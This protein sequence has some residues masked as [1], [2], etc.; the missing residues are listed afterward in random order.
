MA[1][2]IFGRNKLINICVCGGGNLAHAIA[3][4]LSHNDKNNKVS[5]LT[6]KP[7]RW[8]NVLEVQH[9]H[10][11]AYNS[12]L[13]N[14]TN[15]YTILENM[16][17]II[18]SIP[19][20][21]RFEFLTK[22][23]KHVPTHAILVTAPSL[24]GI[25]FIFDKYFPKNKY[26]CLQRVP[27]ICRTVEYG[28]SVNTDIKKEIK[29]LHS[30]NST[31][32]DKNIIKKL[33]K[34]NVV[35]LKSYRALMLSNS[36]PILHIAGMAQLIKEN[37]P[38]NYIPRL[39]DIWD[40]YASNICIEMDKELESIMN[41]YND[42]EYVSLFEHYCVNSTTELTTKLKSITSFKD[43][44][45]PFSEKNGLYYIDKTSRYI[46]EDIPFGTCFIKYVAN[47]NGIKTPAIDQVLKII[48]KTIGEEYV[49]E[50][51]KINMEHW[52]KML[53]YPTD[54]LDYLNQKVVG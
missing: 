12:E 32:N 40:N 16:D 23:K 46:I 10:K 42:T 19:A 50:D 11:F 43:V 21:A 30:T 44:I 27:Y 35:E 45:A 9:D 25:N 20:F 2:L 52:N 33:F 53:G 24:G 26:A 8:S 31:N 37:Y 15:N 29:V 14:I 17:I 36:N 7:E 13:V 18:L 41:K 51:N 49:T 4:E 39:Y 5:I 3:G 54:M 38:Y 28:H 6:R 22:I 1:K 34:M 47:I 48:Q